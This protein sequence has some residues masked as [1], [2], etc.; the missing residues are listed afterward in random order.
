MDSGSHFETVLVPRLTKV[1]YAPDWNDGKPERLP[2]GD[3]VDRSPRVLKIQ[4]LESY[5]DAIH[6]LE[7]TRSGLDGLFSDAVDRSLSLL[8]AERLEQPWAYQIEVLTDDGPRKQKVDLVETFNLV[9]GVHVER[10]QV[11]TN[12]A[13]RRWY[14]AVIGQKGGHRLLILWRD[15]VEPPLD[16]QVERTFLE[17]R[18]EPGAYDEVLINGDSAVP[19]VTSLDPIF[20]RLIEEEDG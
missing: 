10:I 5:E 19:G 1:A 6:N 15:M 12:E 4:R 3:E 17:E 16:P 2:S 7:S 11:W 18:I 13:D 20:K 14:R 8:S 9:Y